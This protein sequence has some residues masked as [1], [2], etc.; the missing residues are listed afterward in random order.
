[1]YLLSHLAMQC[2]GSNHCGDLYETNGDVYYTSKP[3]Q[4]CFRTQMMRNGRC[5]LAQQQISADVV[6]DAENCPAVTDEVD[7]TAFIKP[8]FAGSTCPF[9][10]GVYQMTYSTTAGQVTCGGDAASTAE[11]S[12]STITL[13]SCYSG[14]AT[15]SNP[16]KLTLTCMD[17]I[18]GSSLD[19]DANGDILILGNL[20]I[21]PG[22]PHPT[23][24]CARY[25]IDGGSIMLSLSVEDPTKVKCPRG[26]SYTSA[27]DNNVA[28]VLSSEKCFI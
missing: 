20:Q 27:D 17:D 8:P 5:I 9:T 12:G 19:S 10:D 14:E 25:K 3:L 11:V 18:S 24:Y 23:F 4:S 2:C 15:Y 22:V 7:A 16:T 13:N 6:G 21:L 26:N 28:F 1:M